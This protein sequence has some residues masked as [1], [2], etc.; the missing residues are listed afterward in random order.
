MCIQ[1]QGCLAL[2]GA[3]PLPGQYD[4]HDL[5]SPRLRKRNQANTVI[6]IMQKRNREC[7]SLFMCVC[8]RQTNRQR[9]MVSLLSPPA[10]GEA[11]HRLFHTCGSQQLH[12]PSM[13]SCAGSCGGGEC[14]MMGPRREGGQEGPEMSRGQ[15]VRQGS[16]QCSQ[17]GTQSRKAAAR[18]LTSGPWHRESQRSGQPQNALLLG[19]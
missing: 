18:K 14:V 12:V 8:Y 10:P 17:A 3:A 4:H 6:H 9:Q 16:S 7:V 15:R 13:T 1:Q 19:G 11:V 2:S 5:Y